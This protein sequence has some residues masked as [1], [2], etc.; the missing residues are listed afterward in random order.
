MTFSC[1]LWP[2]RPSPVVR[3]RVWTSASCGYFVDKAK[4]EAFHSSPRARRR[5]NNNCHSAA[6]VRKFSLFCCGTSSASVAR[7]AR[8]S[9]LL[10]L[11][12][13]P[14]SRRPTRRC[15]TRSG[16]D[17]AKRGKTVV[18]SNR[19]HGRFFFWLM[20]VSFFLISKW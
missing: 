13:L 19:G 10:A 11:L 14:C 18:S 9:R 15:A 2:L 6:I 16:V 3:N 1:S 7:R 8:T 5:I 12:L 17:I 20:V 4:P